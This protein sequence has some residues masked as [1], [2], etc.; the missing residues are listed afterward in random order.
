[1]KINKYCDI[2][3][4]VSNRLVYDHEH[5]GEIVGRLVQDI[6]IVLKWS[7][8]DDTWISLEELQQKKEESGVFDT[9]TK[10][11]RILLYQY[12]VKDNSLVPIEIYNSIMQFTSSD[13]ENL[14]AAFVTNNHSAYVRVFQNRMEKVF[15]D[16]VIKSMLPNFLYKDIDQLKDILYKKY[17]HCPEEK[18]NIVD[19]EIVK[20]VCMI[21]V[22]R[23]EISWFSPII[24][25]KYAKSKKEYPDTDDRLILLYEMTETIFIEALKQDH[26]VDKYTNERYTGILAMCQEQQT[27]AFMSKV[28]TFL[29]EQKMCYWKDSMF[30]QE[31]TDYYTS[32][33]E[34]NPHLHTNSSI[35]A[36]YKSKSFYEDTK[37][38]YMDKARTL[39]HATLQMDTD[40]LKNIDIY[41]DLETHVFDKNHYIVCIKEHLKTVI[42]EFSTKKEQTLAKSVQIKHQKPLAT[43]TIIVPRKEPAATVDPQLLQRFEEVIWSFKQ[44]THSKLNKALDDIQTYIWRMYKKNQPVYMRQ[45]HETLWSLF[46]EEV[47]D[48]V[49]NLCEQLDVSIVELDH[50]VQQATKI[51]QQP[52]DTINYDPTWVDT[53]NTITSK[54]SQTLIT[55]QNTP[56]KLTTELL[57]TI[58]KE[59]WYRFWDEKEF[60]W[61]ADK[62]GLD[63]EWRMWIAIKK[64]LIDYLGKPETDTRTIEWSRNTKKYEKLTFNDYSRMVKQK[65]TILWLTD[66]KTYV[67]LIELHFNA[68]KTDFDALM[69]TTRKEWDIDPRCV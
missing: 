60:A 26:L 15:A 38:I 46:D 11:A 9:F 20:N 29:A 54:V 12:F 33:M 65:S 50:A 19:N 5:L 57:I 14:Y 52:K 64:K 37:N 2:D 45:L 18:I 4:Q 39:L 36:K 59:L 13:Y 68:N 1:M 32:I 63:R 34:E 21:N 16:Y 30:D 17:P 62:L 35:R 10:N 58:C 48:L 41:T 69:S 43:M 8:Y 55:I 23:N 40:L 66:H 22:V 25:Q 44:K 28:H 7:S 47:I 53:D 61:Y 51:I 27:K 42:F 24:Q 31:I 67:K 49:R 6:S 3:F 56:E